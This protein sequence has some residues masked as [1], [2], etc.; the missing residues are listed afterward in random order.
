MHS[1]LETELFQISNEIH[2]HSND[3]KRHKQ[4]IFEIDFMCSCESNVLFSQIGYHK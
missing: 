3:T 1:W 2:I 4:Q